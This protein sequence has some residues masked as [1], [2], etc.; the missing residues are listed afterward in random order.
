M[1][2]ILE[3]TVITADCDR[4]DVSIDTDGVGGR[5]VG[6]PGKVSIASFVTIGAKCVSPLEFL[7]CIQLISSVF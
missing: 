3:N 6:I 5:A 7:S 2:N 4:T 1:C